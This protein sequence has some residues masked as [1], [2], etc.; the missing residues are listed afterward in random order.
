MGQDPDHQALDGQ[1]GS[2]QNGNGGGHQIGGLELGEGAAR[3]HD[4]A[5]T[6]ETEG[7]ADHM[8]LRDG[9][10]QDQ[11][12]ER[13]DEHHVEKAKGGRIDDRHRRRGIDQRKTAGYA[14]RRPHRMRKRPGAA[15]DPQAL[16]LDGNDSQ[17]RSETADIAQKL[18][19]QHGHAVATEL[20]RCKDQG[21]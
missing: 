18:D 1:E 2:P 4:E 14:E 8:L 16:A 9:L 15:I 6:G 21:K 10:F 12:G 20:S 13:N 7:D 19:L 5:G 3:Y 17:K 11:H